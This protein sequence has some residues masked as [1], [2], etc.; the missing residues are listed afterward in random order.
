MSTLCVGCPGEVLSSRGL[1]CRRCVLDVLVKSR[2]SV[3]KIGKVCGVSTSC[4]CVGAL[5]SALGMHMLSYASLE[6]TRTVSCVSMFVS[7]IFV[8]KY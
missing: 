5:G 4:L 3:L 7:P 8:S 1:V 6:L 2:K